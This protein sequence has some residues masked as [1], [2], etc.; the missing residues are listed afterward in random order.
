MIT[1]LARTRTFSAF[2]HRNFR[3]YWTGAIVSLV[4]TWVQQTAQSY[5]VW[6]LTRS[7]L[8]TSLPMFFF[9][10]PILLFTLVGGVIADRVD[11]R[12]LLLI[13]QSLFMLQAAVLTALT[14]L[15]VIRVEH[16]YL[17]A[18]TS[19]VIMAIDAPSRQS[20]IPLLVDRE[21][22]TNAIAL[23]SLVFNS[24]RIIGPP[25]GGLLYAAAGPQAAF[26]FNTVTYLGILYPLAAMRLPR[27]GN[28]RS[29]SPWT[30]LRDGLS[31]V[32]GHPLVRTLLLL[33]GMIGTFGFSYL[34]LMPV[35]T[36]QVLG[37]GPAENGYLLGV[38][39]VGSTVG[40][41]VVATT[42]S[43]GY[44]GRRILGMG[45]LAGCAL[46]AFSLSRT[47][48]LSGAALFLVGGA[49]IGFLATANATI[50][51]LV[52][53]ALRGRVMSV[54]SLALMGSGPVNSLL[55]GVL[56]TAVGAPGAIAA[57]ALLILLPVGVLVVR[58][59]TLVAFERRA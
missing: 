46:L 3:L 58:A 20:L 6:E 27:E 13:T 25:I 5:L 2:R 40:A 12:R 23:N 15:R 52:P 35:M 50:Q 16:I 26:L 45:A 1:G 7:P 19:G 36:S 41:L 54:Y 33:V 29:T 28:S 49:I 11:R 21:D 42:G 47:M 43:A 10:L 57:S 31:Y 22:L 39:G 9:T 56:G 59:R 4:G 38:V 14:W 53:D 30:D 48:L 37:G 24:S 55:A 17:L 51:D 32:W 8:A 18:F 34:V 44:P